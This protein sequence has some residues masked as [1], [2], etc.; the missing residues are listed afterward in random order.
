MTRRRRRQ[1]PRDVYDWLAYAV[2]PAAGI[3]WGSWLILTRART[4]PLD[5]TIIV[6]LVGLR[7]VGRPPE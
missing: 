2:A 3:A 5:V 7:L 1:D 6:T 4:E